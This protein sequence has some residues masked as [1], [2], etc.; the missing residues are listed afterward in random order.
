[1]T[2]TLW[3]NARLATLAAGSP[4]GWI[5]RGALLVPLDALATRLPKLLGYADRRVV[6]VCRAG[7]R[8]ASACALLKRAGFRHVFNL[9]NGMLAWVKAGQPVQK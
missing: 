8:S 1:M 7:A 2:T 6:C 5:E 3:R 9:E 4:W